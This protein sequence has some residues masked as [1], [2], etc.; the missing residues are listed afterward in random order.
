M[1]VLTVTYVALGLLLKINWVLS[2]ISLP[3]WLVIAARRL[4]DLDRTGWWGLVPF[5][6]GF[7]GGFV[8]G[9]S[10]HLV[11]GAQANGVSAICGALTTIVSLAFI[12]WLG[13]SRGT[14]GPNRFGPLRPVAAVGPVEGSTTG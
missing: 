12:I 7:I 9:F 5:G 4:H 14:E 11:D 6:A 3:F 10:K 13:A 1:L 2:F 8:V